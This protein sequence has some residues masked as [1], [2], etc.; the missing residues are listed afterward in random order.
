MATLSAAPLRATLSPPS[1]ATG[2][3]TFPA[4]PECVSTRVSAEHLTGQTGLMGDAERGP[5][6]PSRTQRVRAWVGRWWWVGI[7]V[8]VV[9]IVKWWIT[10]PTLTLAYLKALVWPILVGTVL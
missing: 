9:A 2:S 8:A 10:D 5:V 1:V 3:D 7:P 4:M 6:G